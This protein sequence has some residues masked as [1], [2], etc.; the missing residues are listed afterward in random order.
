MRCAGGARDGARR[1]HVRRLGQ[2][3]RALGLRHRL[4]ALG[5]LRLAQRGVVVDQVLLQHRELVLL[6]G[7]RQVKLHQVPELDQAGDHLHIH[8]APP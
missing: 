5:A 7:R 1:T 3:Q 6:G 8:A 4:G 2:P